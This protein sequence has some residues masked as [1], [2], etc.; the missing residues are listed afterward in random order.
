MDTSLRCPASLVPMAHGR[1]LKVAGMLVHRCTAGMRA[2]VAAIGTAVQAEHRQSMREAAQLCMLRDAPLR[3]VGG[4]AEA[5]H[6]SAGTA[7][8]HAPR[9]AG[10]G[11]VT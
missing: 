3:P 8:R 11:Y 1:M 6:C 10:R 5:L 9:Q 4:V 7:L 2:T